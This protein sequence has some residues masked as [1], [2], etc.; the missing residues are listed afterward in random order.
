MGRT[1]ASSWDVG[2]DA[3]G[4]DKKT[5][6]DEKAVVEGLITNLRNA[7]DFIV[8]IGQGHYEGETSGHHGAKPGGQSAQP[9]GLP[10]AHA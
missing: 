3:A 10:P 8:Q 7:T 5:E 2:A 6:V 4:I 1:A 9:F